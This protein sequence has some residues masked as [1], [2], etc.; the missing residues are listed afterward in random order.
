[1]S[2]GVPVRNGLGI[3][4]LPSTTLSSLRIGGRPALV[5]NFIGTTALDSRIAFTRSTTG[6]FIGSNGLIQSAAINAPRFD[7]NPTTLA[8]LGLLMEEGR[9]N[10]FLNSLIDGTSLSTQ[11]V[12]VSAVSYTL[13]FYGTGTITLAGAS[14]AVVTGTGV[15]PS[16]RTLTFTPTAGALICTVVGSVQYAQIE[17]GTFA[18]SFI[19]TAGATVVRGA[20]AAS[21]TGANFTSFYNASEGSLFTSGDW[22]GIS[23]NDYWAALDS[24]SN[25]N[26]VGLQSDSFGANLGSVRSGGAV[27]ASMNIGTLTANVVYNMAIAYKVND[28][29]ACRNGGTVVT[30]NA[31]VVPVSVTRLAIGDGL[32]PSGNTLNGHVRQITYYNTRLPNATLQDLTA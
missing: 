14:V 18:T 29:A 8:P 11:T 1:M 21:I 4:L 17:T 28:F 27:Q 23:G 5:L 16:R 15:Y 22:F 31:G 30:D 12:T 7:Y 6:T 20:D 26:G 3:G 32:A 13:S 24:A 9:T 25:Q 19:P 10:L 2:F